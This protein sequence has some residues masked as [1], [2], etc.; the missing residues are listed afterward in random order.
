[1]LKFLCTVAAF[2]KKAYYICSP[3]LK[4]ILKAGAVKADNSIILPQA[5]SK[6]TGYIIGY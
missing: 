6:L 2:T 4:K 3:H 1:M 5:I